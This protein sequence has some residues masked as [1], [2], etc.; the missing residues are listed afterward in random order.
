MRNESHKPWGR[1]VRRCPCLLLPWGGGGGG[2]SLEPALN[3][4]PCGLREAH[5]VASV[6]GEPRS[7]TLIFRRWGRVPAPALLV[8]TGSSQT[9]PY[10]PVLPYKSDP[11]RW[12]G[13]LTWLPALCIRTQATVTPERGPQETAK[14]LGTAALSRTRRQERRHCLS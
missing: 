9:R 5:A 14:A 8:L 13:V 7:H 6:W 1:T 2:W 4:R 10:S 12:S 3:A 11:C